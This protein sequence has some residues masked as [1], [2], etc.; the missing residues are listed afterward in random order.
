MDVV[1]ALDAGTTSVRTLAV[2]SSGKILTSSQQEFSQNYP[3]PGPVSYT[4]LPLP[5]IYSV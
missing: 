1:L 2:D 5:T 4:H 3:E